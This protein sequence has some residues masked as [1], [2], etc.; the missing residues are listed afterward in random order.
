MHCDGAGTKNRRSP[1]VLGKKK[2][3]DLSGCGKVIATDAL[4]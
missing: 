1:I 3:S 2:R 4:I